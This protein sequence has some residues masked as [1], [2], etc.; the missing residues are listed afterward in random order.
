MTRKAHYANCVIRW[1]LAFAAVVLTISLWW[2]LAPADQFRYD[3][4]PSTTDATTYEPGDLVVMTIPGFCNDGVATT[5]TRKLVGPYGALVL[6]PIE[7]FAPA[8]PTCAA[9]FTAGVLI[10]AEV[11]PGEWRITMETSW[12]ANPM[13]AVSASVTSTA[14]AVV[15]KKK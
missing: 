12:Q 15:A 2:L 11:P 13:R 10:P 6:S 14:F 4:G 5:V 7:F 9:P 8:E 3:A 1:A